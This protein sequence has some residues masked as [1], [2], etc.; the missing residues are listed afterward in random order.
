MILK[1]AQRGGASSLALHVLNTKDN[2][3]VRVH[4]LRGVAATN[5]YG[6]FRE[7][8]AVASATNSTK[9]FFSVSFN[10]PPHASLTTEQFEEAFALVE[11]KMGLEQSQRVVLFHEKNARIHAHVCWSVIQP[12]T[13]TDRRFSEAQEVEKL[14]A[15]KLGLYKHKLNE[16]SRE[17]FLKF[18]LEMPRGFQEKGKADPLSYDRH[19]WMQCQNLKEDPRDLKALVRSAY[20]QSK[21]AKGLKQRL[22]EHGLFLCRGPHDKFLMIH[23]TGKVMA[24]TR[25]TGLKAKDLREHLGNASELPVLEQAESDRVKRITTALHR[26]KDDLRAKHERDWQPF[27]REVHALKLRQRQERKQLQQKQDART[28]EE[29]LIRANRLRK[30]ITGVFDRIIGHRG[31]TITR[32][33][34]ELEQC[35][36][37]DHA[38]REAL[39]AKH[40]QERRPIQ[41]DIDRMKQEHTRERQQF[42]TK[43]GFL[44]S[45]DASEKD[46]NATKDHIQERDADRREQREA[47]R[48]TTGRGRERTRT[49]G[50]EDPSP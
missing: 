30:G 14:A 23:H 2:D 26:M 39:I 1:G 34:Q 24:L 28:K 45:L 44:L 22:E 21:S 49:Q 32:N 25:Y 20:Q 33:Q 6:A 31:R 37:R 9:P 15:V 50:P 38:E 18:G 47:D 12:V 29:T 11:Q 48:G 27:K 41:Q 10:P 43:M 46:R 16:C 17:L 40:R 13:K 4:D 42:R 19:V 3:H 5:A 8:E 7:M 36:R 35:Q